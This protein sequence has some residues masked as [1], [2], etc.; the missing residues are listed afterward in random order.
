MLCLSMDL[1]RSSSLQTSIP[2]LLTALCMSI[3]IIHFPDLTPK[4]LLNR[5]LHRRCHLNT[6]RA[7]RILI[8]LQTNQ[9][10]PH[11][12]LRAPSSPTT[13]SLPA[14]ICQLGDP[15]PAR[16][17]SGCV[18]SL[19]QELLRLFRCLR[20]LLVGL[21]V[22]GLVEGVDVFAGCGDCFVFLLL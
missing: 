13:L 10:V 2:A 3:A 18:F 22:V 15:L 4:P 17:A 9:N 1:A 19:R 5:L 14:Q 20:L 11:P 16:S 7:W 12:L 21:A 8:S 6:A